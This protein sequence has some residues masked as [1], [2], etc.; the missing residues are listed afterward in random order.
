MEVRLAPATGS[1]GKGAEAMLVSAVGEDICLGFANTLT[2]RGSA[3]PVETLADFAALLTW[4]QASAALPPPAGRELARWGDEH[5]LKAAEIFAEAVVLRE[6]IYRIASALACSEPIRGQDFAALGR[7]VSQAPARRQI[8]RA[9]VG[10][11]WRIELG[12]VS[13]AGVSAPTLLAPVLWSAADLVVGDARRRIRRCANDACLWLFVDASKNGTRRWCD[14][15]SCGN[16]A[17]A[18]RHYLK[19]KQG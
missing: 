12:K 6:A 15:A 4:A 3:A 10:Y 5:P 18:R 8:V 17:K 2:W 7:A 9:S 11:A 19:I 1:N 14:M 13:R 16:R